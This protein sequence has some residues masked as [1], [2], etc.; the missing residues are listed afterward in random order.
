[1][2]PRSST[3]KPSAAPEVSSEENVHSLVIRRI[4]SATPDKVFA[5]FTRP[6]LARQWMAPG[7]LGVAEAEI[8]ARVGGRFRIVML[9]PDGQT[10]SPGG[11]YEEIIL[12]EKLVFTWKWA[13]EE[14]MTRV[15]VELRAVGT[16]KT[17]ITLTHSGFAD[18]A[19]RSSHEEGWTG[20]FSKLESTV[21]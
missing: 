11:E 14:L 21:A 1:M 9:A 16:G 7:E 13:H 2:S 18:A 4:L 15:T 5:A 6:E 3:T 10:H 20:C 17:E 12:N 19:M 8:D